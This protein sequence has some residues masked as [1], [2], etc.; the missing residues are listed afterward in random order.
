MEESGEDVDSSPYSAP[1]QCKLLVTG[2]SI[3]IS[4][5]ISTST[6]IPICISIS[7]SISIISISISIS[8]SIISISISSLSFSME[9]CAGPYLDMGPI[10]KATVAVI[11]FGL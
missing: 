6:S 9:S 2:V 3:S 5:S 4:I 11:Q 7:I 10:T 8:I 1:A